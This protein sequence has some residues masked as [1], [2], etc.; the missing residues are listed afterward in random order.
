MVICLSNIAMLHFSC[1]RRGIEASKALY[2]HMEALWRL[3]RACIFPDGRLF[4]IDGDTRVRYCYCQDYL[5]PSLYMI[6]DTL[7]DDCDAFETGWLNML[8][9]ET[10]YNG[11]GSFLSKRCELFV[12]RSPLYFTRLES[13]RACTLSMACLWRRQFGEMKEPAGCGSYAPDP[14]WRAPLNDWSNASMG[15]MLTRG[16][17]RLASFVWQGAEPPTALIASPKGQFHGRM[18]QKPDR[19]HGGRRLYQSGRAGRLVRSFV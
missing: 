9:R 10:A 7:G 17:H 8:D 3:I 4:R 5:L 18:A 19:L 2:H 12:E 14:I 11:D 16:E 1:R 6:R 15:G 13:D